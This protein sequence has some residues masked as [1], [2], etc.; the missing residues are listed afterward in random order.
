VSGMTLA[1]ALTHGE[2]IERPFRCEQHDDN[3]ASASVNVLKM[4][5]YCYTCHASGAADK[6]KAPSNDALESMISPDRLAR[7]YPQSYLALFADPGYWLTRFPDW[8]CHEMGL[9][10][11]PFTGD[12]VF[13][14]HTGE[15]LLAG[16]GRRR[17][18]T[19]IVGEKKIEVQGT[20]YLYPKVWAASQTLF[21]SAGRWQTHPVIA[22]VEGAADAS[23]CWEV[24]APGFAVYGSGLHL[25][26]ID[27]VA[28]MQPRLVLLGFDMD[29]AGE[30]AV[31][32]AF[33]AL[34]GIAPMKRVRWP[35][36]DKDPAGTPYGLRKEILHRTVV[37]AGY[38]EVV[39]QWTAWRRAARLRYASTLE[40]A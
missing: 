1:E 26:Q 17:L 7:V 9:G 22:L 38:G 2:G 28:R 27:L 15:G 36:R 34:A 32:R 33:G 18:V 11:D 40:V 6:K 13:P 31:T 16:I 8:L 25:P 10:Q 24:G 21:G 4:V 35:R 20:R 19:E 5:W 3:H 29:E 23:A 37:D 14:V 12:G 30:K 39:P